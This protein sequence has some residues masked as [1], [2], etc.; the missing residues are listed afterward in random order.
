MKN[1]ENLLKNLK[2]QTIINFL[3][4]IIF[5]ILYIIVKTSL[6]N[7]ISIKSETEK[8]KN[9]FDMKKRIDLFYDISKN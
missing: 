2:S 9:K 8:I 5:I 7:K 3:Q 1:I 6:S 4:K